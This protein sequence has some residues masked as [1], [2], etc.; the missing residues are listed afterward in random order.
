MQEIARSLSP[1][2]SL[3]FFKSVK[4]ELETQVTYYT[5]F[6]VE[7]LALEGLLDSDGKPRGLA[8]LVAHLFEV[9][10]ANLVLARLLSSG[11]LHDYLRKAENEVKKAERETHLTVKLTNILAWFL[12]RRR[13]P[14]TYAKWE[15]IPNVRKKNRPFG[16][17]VEGKWKSSCPALMPLP[18]NILL[19]VKRYNDNVFKCFQ[20]LAFAVSTTK[21]M[22]PDDFTLPYTDQRFP[23]SF[24]DCGAENKNPPFSGKEFTSFIC[25]QR[26]RSPFSALT[27]S[28]DELKTPHD[29]VKYT[30]CV[31]HFDLNSVPMVAP[32]QILSSAGDLEATNSWVVDFM[33]HGKMKYLLDDNG[34]DSTKA[35]RMIS[36]FIDSLKMMIAVLKIY[37]IN[38]RPSTDDIVLKTLE[39]IVK[40]MQDKLRSK[41]NS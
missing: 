1:A 8:N 31:T 4:V 30:R 34:I 12:Y 21:K 20:D 3:P 6:S 36:S 2:F 28:G 25:R 29:L 10:P 5:R 41:A 35:W 37:M 18:K 7:L 33:T 27:G 16:C 14:D 32:P 22:G 26:V 9:E 13:L 19:E 11:V 17:T 40:E 24:E 38:E 23:A 39:E 15:G